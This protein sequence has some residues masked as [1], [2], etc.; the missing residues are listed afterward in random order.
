VGGVFPPATGYRLLL[1][2]L[3]TAMNDRLSALA[4]LTIICGILPAGLS[5]AT[6]TEDL[7]IGVLPAAGKVVIDGK[8]D[9]WR[10]GGGVFV[11]GDVERLRDS[12]A[13]WVHL[14]YDAQTLYVLVRW[15][16]TTPLNNRQST[17]GGLGFQGD[18]FQI[19][20]LVADRTPRA[21]CSHLTCWK[22]ADGRDVVKAD[23]G[24][25]FDGGGLP[26]AKTKGAR[27]AFAV[28]ADG[29]GY[30]Q[31]IAIPWK[32]LTADGKRP[33]AGDALRVTVATSFSVAKRGHVTVR[34]LRNPTGPGDTD[35]RPAYQASHTW[36]L[37]T[38]VGKVHPLP[39][40]LRLADGRELPVRMAGGAPAVD[41]SALTK[42]P[43]PP[44]AGKLTVTFPPERYVRQRDAND[45]G[46]FAIEGSCLAAAGGVVQARALLRKGMNRG[47]TTGWVDAARAGAGGKFHGSVT[48]KA[49][50]WYRLQLRAVVA[51]KIVART[52]VEKVG[53]GEVFIT[54]GQSNSGN[55]GL[56][57]QL[58]KDDRVVYRRDDN[59]YVPARDPIPGSIN[60]VSHGGN[61]WP[62][63][64]D[65]LARSC[66]APICF[67]GAT[68]AHKQVIAWK[69]GGRLCKDLAGQ[70][71]SFGPGGVRAVLWHQGEYDLGA[72]TTSQQYRDRLGETI[73][74]VRK[75]AGYDLDWFVSAA[76]YFP[77]IGP[78]LASRRAVGGQ[79]RLWREGIAFQGP[80]TEDLG[81]AF[82][83]PDR[84]HFNQLGL[85]TFADRWYA[86]IYM[87]YFAEVPLGPRKKGK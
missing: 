40:A 14:M 87:R 65:L 79:K 56:P 31:E 73:R 26:D 50:G 57:P 83:I 11:S 71:K 84:V 4:L 21:R 1:F 52:A 80:T 58:A 2:R 22:G 12:Q 54:A 20:F 28:S 5:F 15:R 38:F 64:G 75:Q 85:D 69:P 82:R 41:W 49:G 16:D 61:P 68:L 17:A 30:L 48:L 51:W 10:L 6:P 76:A 25:M 37:A 7:G 55:S 36:A 32:L 60:P 27:Q 19:R 63:L 77:V 35:R 44:A 67:R 33:R 13:A 29:N 39:E 46:A 9:D 66:Q 62:R 45:D 86:V 74:T 78:N 59:T 18:C 34:D 53:V 81:D 23:Y 72:R 24:K 3:E 42:R 43:A 47:R 70:V 8:A